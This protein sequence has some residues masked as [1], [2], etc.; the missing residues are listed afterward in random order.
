M[1][2]LFK[3][4][5]PKKLRVDEFR[6]AFLS[7]I[8]ETER[9]ISKDWKKITETWDHDVVWE[10]EISLKGGPSVKVSSADQILRWLNDG[11]PPHNIFAKKSMGYL[12]YQPGFKPKTK[13]GWIGSQKGGKSGP[14]VMRPS[15]RHPGF[16]ARNY[17][18]VMKEKW[19]PEFNKI[20]KKWMSKAVK[21]SGHGV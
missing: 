15:V 11:T 2:F 3:P 18:K 6:L 9:G 20:V 8:H 7:A 21:Q 14:A 16:E 4:I 1:I 10:V 12:K 13:V 17:E 5:T 19:E